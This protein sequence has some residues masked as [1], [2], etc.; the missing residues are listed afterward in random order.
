VGEVRV[1]RVL[2]Q[3]QLGRVELLDG[4]AG[5][6]VRRVACGNG[7][8]GSRLV[9]RILLGRERSALRQLAGL[10]GVA[11]VL[12]P[13]TDGALEGYLRASGNGGS[14]PDP[15]EV[16]LRSWIE[17]TPLSRARELPR[18][19]FAQLAE[20]VRSVHA[21][22]VRHNDLHKEANVLVG[23]D[24]RPALLDFQLA[25]R[26]AREGPVARSR[27][28]DDLRHV[29]KHRAVYCR[30]LGPDGGPPLVTMQRSWLAGAWLSCAKPIYRRVVRPRSQRADGEPRRAPGDP[31]P[32]WTAPVGSRELMVP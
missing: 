25:S 21:R 4:P 13:G 12:E 11:S 20:L 7:A 17:G 18:D 9:A 16:L 3:D 2:K 29:E 31:A 19:F 24:G 26:H 22:G 32:C 15:R 14:A 30:M 10:P 28:R 1:V 27:A 5:P 8:A 23:A 6:L